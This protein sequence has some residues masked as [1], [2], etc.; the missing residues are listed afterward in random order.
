MSDRTVRVKVV[1]LE[2]DVEVGQ[3][4][5]TY[6]ETQPYEVLIDSPDGVDARV[7][8]RAREGSA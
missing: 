8:R 7:K 4:E 5:V 3:I 2:D 6:F 1:V